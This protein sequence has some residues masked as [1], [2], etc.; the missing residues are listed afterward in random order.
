MSLFITFEGIEG[1]GKSTQAK[2]LY[3]ALLALSINAILTREPGGTRL[4]ED[5]RSLILGGKGVDDPLTEMLLLSAARR[6]HVNK[7]IIPNIEQGNVVISDRFFD[8]SIVYQGY[9]KGLAIDKSEEISK[10]A[11]G[12]F[13]PN[14]T[15]LI[16]LPVDVA[17]KRVISRGEEKSV[18]DKSSYSFHERIRAGFLELASHD[19]KRFCILDGAVSEEELHKKVL[20]V[21][22]QLNNQGVI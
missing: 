12:N 16:D 4:A 1:S 10:I 14:L 19:P 15:F 6:D 22:K 13:L 20:D 18:Y 5:I 11:I 7:L 9:V 8:S 2:L 3:K 17:M 21:C